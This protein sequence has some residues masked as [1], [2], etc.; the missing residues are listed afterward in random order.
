MSG[1]S[2]LLGHEAAWQD[3]RS[4]MSGE[5]MHHAWLLSGHRGL[6]KASFAKLAASELVAQPEVPQPDSDAHPDILVL[7]TLPSSSDEEKKRQEGKPYTRKRGI[8][9]DQIRAMQRRLT[10]RPTLGPRRAVI[11][12]SADDLE[13]SAVNALLKSLE[14]PPAGTI[15]LLVAHR[16]GGLL[17]T[18][19]SRCRQ[20]RFHGLAS[21]QLRQMLMGRDPNLS[22]DLA[23]AAID[24]AQ[25]SPGVALSFI[26]EELAPIAK[27]LQ[28]IILHGDA[29]FVRRGALAAAIGARPDRERLLAG[30]RLARN[31][32][33]AHARQVPRDRQ[34]ALI[35][36][37]DSLVKLGSEIPYANFDPGL[38]VVEIGGLL[39]SA[40]PPKG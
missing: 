27:E 35:D 18:V 25:G 34:A 23:Q 30:V 20:L 12:D 17:P 19:R 3:W 31:L 6:G 22:P 36:V 15:F 33:A 37:H 29:D 38:T 16:P 2:D 9:V 4:A 32:C 8:G 5:R 10:T 39:A 13:K 21:G 24:A 26:G 40:A 11:I 14:E 28:N 1:G 7:E